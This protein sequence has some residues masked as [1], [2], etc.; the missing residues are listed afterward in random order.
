MPSKGH[1]AQ[2][3]SPPD[4]WQ[5]IG[6]SKGPVPDVRVNGFIRQG[7]PPNI[8][9]PLDGTLRTPCIPPSRQACAI[10][11]SDD[12]SWPN[13]SASP[14]TATPWSFATQ[15]SGSEVSIIPSP[16]RACNCLRPPSPWL[17]PS[18]R[19]GPRHRRIRFRAHRVGVA[20]R[21]RQ[22]RNVMAWYTSFSRLPSPTSSFAL[23]AP[24]AFKLSPRLIVVRRWTPQLFVIINPPPPRRWPTS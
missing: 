20:R 24:L 8:P 6:S 11:L 13:S 3:P 23:R 17:D 14:L 5:E 4:G 9:P 16:H 1:C 10:S 18:P 2:R 15:P 22:M 21:C 19:R 7:R 12:G